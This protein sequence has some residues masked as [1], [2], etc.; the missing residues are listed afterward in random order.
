MQRQMFNIFGDQP[1]VVPADGQMDSP[2]FSAKYCTYS[3]MH[4][5]LDYILHVEIVDVSHAQLKSSA[6]VKVG[7]ERAIDALMRNLNVKELVTDASSQII[8]LHR[9]Y[10]LSKCSIIL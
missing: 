4:A 8:K 10:E 6:M 2:G 1:V 7:C 9:K 3:L 5:T